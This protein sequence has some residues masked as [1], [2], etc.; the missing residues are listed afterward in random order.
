MSN[1]MTLS[2]AVAVAVGCVGIANMTAQSAPAGTLL[3]LSKADRT[4][5]LVDPV[6]LKVLGAVPSGPDPH[7]VTVSTDGRTAYISNYNAGSSTITVVDLASRKVVSPVDLGPLRAPHG[8]A[9]AAGKLWFT[10]EASKAIGSYDPASGKVDW[11]L[12]TGQNRTHMIFAA[13]DA[14]WLVTSNVT[15]ATMTFIEKT[16][17]GGRGGPGS[18]GGVGARGGPPPEAAA[19]GR[20]PGQG[21]WDETVIPVGRGAEGFDVSP[22]GKEL[23]AANAQDGTISIIDIASKR[24]TDTLAARVNGA[25]RLKF[26]PD[27]KLVFVSTLGG[28]DLTIIDAVTRKDV[29]RLPVGRAAG[30]LMQPDGARAYVACTPEDHVEIID[31]KTLAS[32]GRI[33]A[34]KQPDGLAW[35]T[36][37]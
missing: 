4:L 16:A 14:R 15:S 21:D 32:A 1:V 19:R 23:W 8:L 20:G 28:T 7:E 9:F 25:N 11:V 36:A 22:D 34:G 26:T 30:I 37:R 35:T 17:G 24:V 10:A 12:G 6:T 29:K 13:A 2:L 3:V 31:L 18:P 33:E 27:G 5:S